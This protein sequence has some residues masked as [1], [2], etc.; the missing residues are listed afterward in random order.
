MKWKLSNRKMVLEVCAVQSF[1]LGDKPNPRKQSYE[2][3][4]NTNGNGGEIINN[5]PQLV[6]CNRNEC[7][8]VNH[9][10]FPPSWW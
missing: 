9:L 7:F 5:Q 1:H 6:I 3:F 2:P 8:L 4:L 10:L